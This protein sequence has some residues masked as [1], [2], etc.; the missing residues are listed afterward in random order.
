M[1]TTFNF[2]YEDRERIRKLTESVNKLA[3]AVEEGNEINRKFM[4]KEGMVEEETPYRISPESD[5]SWD[6]R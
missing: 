4:K 1:G 6:K 3:L 2:S 5:I